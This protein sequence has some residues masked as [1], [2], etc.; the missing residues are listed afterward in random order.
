M[1]QIGKIFLCYF[2]VFLVFG[3][4]IIDIL[5]IVWP[6][7][8][9]YTMFYLGAFFGTNVLVSVFLVIF[10]FHFKFCAVSRAAA[11]AELAF[12]LNYL[13]VQEDNMYN[14]LFQIIGG[15]FALIVTIRSYVKKFPLCKISLLYTFMA[16]L[17][18]SGSCTSAMDSWQKEIT[19]RIKQNL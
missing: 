18:R 14:L 11:L 15:S 13:I 4:V 1:K 16:L 9:F 10:V 3:Q 7:A 17:I 5:A 12:A 8:Y 6:S 19:Y 2:P